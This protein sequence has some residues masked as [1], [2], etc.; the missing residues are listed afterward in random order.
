M[1]HTKAKLQ[2]TWSRHK[3]AGLYAL[4][5][6]SSHQPTLNEWTKTPHTVPVVLWYLSPVTAL[7]L[8]ESEL[9]STRQYTKECTRTHTYTQKHTQSLRRRRQSSRCTCRHTQTKHKNP[10]AQNW[11]AH[12]HTVYIT[13]CSRFWQHTRTHAHTH[14][15]TGQ[16]IFSIPRSGLTL[17]HNNENKLFVYFALFSS[18]IFYLFSNMGDMMVFLQLGNHK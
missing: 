17:L 12:F 4:V 15:Q 16:S 3:L 2:H 9:I 1:I 8:M 18:W 13:A 6:S 5:H 11:K 7:C 10:K 14:A